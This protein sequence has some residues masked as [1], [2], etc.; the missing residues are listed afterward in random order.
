MFSDIVQRSH[1]GLL[2]KDF[3]E[4]GFVFKTTLH[5][6]PVKGKVSKF[7]F[8]HFLFSF[9]N[10]ESI[11]EDLQVISKVEINDLR[12]VLG[13]GTYLSARVRRFTFGSR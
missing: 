6:N 8:Q 13:V 12:E 2:F 1:A 3:V 9:F 10:S 7:A 5:G 11:D 4:G